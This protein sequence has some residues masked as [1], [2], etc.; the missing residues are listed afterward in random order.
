MNKKTS[1]TSVPLNAG[2]QAAGVGMTN[3]FL[4]SEA[5][6]HPARISRDGSDY[7]GPAQETMTNTAFQNDAFGVAVERCREAVVQSGT[8]PGNPLYNTTGDDVYH[9]GGHLWG[10]P[11]A[12]IK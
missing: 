4:A 2:V 6:A 9:R 5:A 12:H 11:E 7:R 3:A 1:G 8:Y 10:R